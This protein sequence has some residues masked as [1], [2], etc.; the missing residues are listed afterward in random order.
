LLEKQKTMETEIEK[1]YE[2]TVLVIPKDPSLALQQLKE[3]NRLAE[4]QNNLLYKALCQYRL[5]QTYRKLL[6]QPE[7]LVCLM[8]CFDYFKDS[9]LYEEFYKVNISLGRIYANMGKYVESLDYILKSLQIAE[10]QKK[11]DWIIRTQNT[12]GLLY[13]RLFDYDQSIKHY[14]VAH[15]LLRTST[16]DSPIQSMKTN[17]FLGNTYTRMR[18]FDRAYDHF[19]MAYTEIRSEYNTYDILMP[20]RGF[21][22]LYLEQKMPEKA[23]QFIDRAYER[24]EQNQ[25]LFSL[26]NLYLLDADYYRQLE[27]YDA[28]IDLLNKGLKLMEQ[29]DVVILRKQLLHALSEVYQQNLNY[30]ES[31][32]SLK[33][34]YKLKEKSISE[35]TSLNILHLE[36]K[37][38]V[39]E[40]EKA[41]QI[42]EET[43][44]IKENLLLNL[45]HEINTPLNSISGFTQ[46]L[47]Q[48]SLQQEQLDYLKT[49]QK[50]VNTLLEIIYD[51]LELSKINNGNNTVEYMEFNIEDLLKELFA[52]LQ[53]RSTANDVKLIYE[54]DARIPAWV[55]GDKKHLTQILINLI[56]N[57]IKF[58][59]KT[60][61]LVKITLNNPL[62][63]KIKL[64]ISV[65]DEGIGIPT[66]FLPHI[67]ET[68]NKASTLT[69]KEYGGTGLGLSICK[70]LVEMMQGSI[71]VT[72]E[73]GK[74][75]TFNVQI[76]VY[77]AKQYATKAPTN[78]RFQS[79]ESSETIR[80]LVVE[81]NLFNQKLVEKSI[82]LTL[83]NSTIH[84][85]EDG[86]K[87]LQCLTN[88]EYDVILMD[89]QMPVLNGFETTQIIRSKFPFPKNQTPILALTANVLKS[90]VE[91]CFEYGMND[92]ISKPFKIPELIKKIVAI[93]KK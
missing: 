39:Q 18:M 80:I 24:L 3:I 93:S 25:E 26:V 55:N 83:K 67:F 14:L 32:E 13:G 74:G 57:A 12:L 1:L 91:K 73:L 48:T 78:N 56:G 81:D 8:S 36:T 62:V 34:Y 30:K 16:S 72:S 46:L 76:P 54:I 59:K 53:I 66:E 11:V 82:Q 60:S 37:Y 20:I 52:M 42:A 23:K 84:I 61:V 9:S 33:E 40:T 15:Q 68:F 41:R 85:A 69:N 21:A 45:S 4:S 17:C 28:S 44:K 63:E 51:I 38:K 77:K 79:I 88:N 6:N 5:A 19:S 71:A 43:A 49:I 86:E 92:Y 31:L 27:K 75:T 70:K 7:E 29:H 10:D 90:E 22:Y 35:E 47:L 65:I 2:S 87:A 58:S 50:S 64:N 89:I